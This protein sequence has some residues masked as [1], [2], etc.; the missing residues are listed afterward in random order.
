MVES[1]HNQTWR[2]TMLVFILVSV[3]Y[4]SE[5]ISDNTA[6]CFG[7]VDSKVQVKSM[8]VHQLIAILVK[9]EKLVVFPLSY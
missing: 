5:H 2:D 6:F 7:T 4:N 8:S 1:N 9:L 3:M